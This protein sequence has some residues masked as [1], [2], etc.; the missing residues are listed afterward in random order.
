MNETF[1][2]ETCGTHCILEMYDCPGELLNDRD[3]VVKSICKAS[4]HGLATLLKHVS[5]KFHPQGVTALC[6]LAESHI[7][8]HT[9]P[10]KGYAA[11]DIFTCGNT[12]NPRLACDYMIDAFQSGR[13]NLRVIPRGM[14]APGEQPGMEH[15]ES[16][17]AV[18]A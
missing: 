15:V 17:A 12:A 2:T 6:L 1:V 16:A 5:Y 18:L 13:Q 3:H 9:W 8:I 14:F 7:S 11:V 4:R 10:E